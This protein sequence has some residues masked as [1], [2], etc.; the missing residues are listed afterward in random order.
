MKGALALLIPAHNAAQFLPRLLGSAAAQTRP[1]DEI[2]VYDD[3]SS[4]ETAEVAEEHGAKVVR[5]TVNCGCSRGKNVLANLTTCEWIHF[6][7]ADDQLLPQFVDRAHSW[8]KRDEHDVVVFGSME[9]EDATGR[10]I[11]QSVHHCDELSSDPIGYTIE[12]K[13]SA[14]SGIYRRSAFLA[15]G[16]FDTDPDVLYNEDVAMHCSL[17]RAGLRFAADPEVMMI[18]WRRPES[19][20]AANPAKCFRAH[21]HV[22]LKA[23]KHDPGRAYSP[24]IAERLWE[25]AGNAASMLDWKTADASG[26]LAFRLGG[27]NRDCFESCAVWDRALHCASANG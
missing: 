23:M 9:R 7:D 17:A 25:N 14:N 24:K 3:C 22:M 12:T 16:G 11:A 19:M 27:G 1:F 26:R 6:H 4:D 20:S 5:G 21:L 18:N 8:M 2:W 15:A 10:I 13:I